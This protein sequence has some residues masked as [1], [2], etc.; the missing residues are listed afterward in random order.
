MA[1][2]KNISTQPKRRSRRK[3]LALDSYADG[4]TDQLVEDM[5]ILSNNMSATNATSQ[6]TLPKKF[7]M[8]TNDQQTLDAYRDNV[9]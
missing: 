9:P 4:K 1:S 5:F 3:K 2:Y 8:S 7:S 6:S